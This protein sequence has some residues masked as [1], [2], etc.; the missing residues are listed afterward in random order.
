MI[1]PDTATIWRYDELPFVGQTF[2]N[3]F[4]QT[5]TICGGPNAGSI[6]N[7]RIIRLAEKMISIL[8]HTVPNTLL[9]TWKPSRLW[10]ELDQ[11]ETMWN[12]MFCSLTRLSPVACKISTKHLQLSCLAQTTCSLQIP[13]VLH[14][15]TTHWDCVTALNPLCL[16][17]AADKL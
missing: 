6:E 8:K 2:L 10:F 9:T 16:T 11:I 4:R 13:F 15:S 17:L 3:E 7:D 5:S 12:I 1:T 14:S